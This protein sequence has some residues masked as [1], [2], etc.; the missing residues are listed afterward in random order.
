MQAPSGEQL[1]LH[2]SRTSSRLWHHNMNFICWAI[3]WLSSRI[4]SFGPSGKRSRAE[5]R[6]FARQRSITHRLYFLFVVA[7]LEV[8]Y[9]IPQAMIYRAKNDWWYRREWNTLMTI[10]PSF[11]KVHYSFV[12]SGVIPH[13]F[14]WY[15]MGLY[16]TF[17]KPSRRGSL[18]KYHTQR[19]W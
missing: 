15:L 8:P 13:R 5:L 18:P 16:S 19:L 12:I 3:S 1:L 6:P 2:Q 7:E 10:P 17:T 9:C 11:L 14:S 4:E